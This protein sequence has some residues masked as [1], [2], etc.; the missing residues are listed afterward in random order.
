MGGGLGVDDRFTG[1]IIT[2]KI[3]HGLDDE[4]RHCNRSIVA[5]NFKRTIPN[6][7]L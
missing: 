7:V 6:P 3:R 5:K 1:K 4:G 2:G